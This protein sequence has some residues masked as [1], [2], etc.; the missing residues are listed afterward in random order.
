[1]PLHIPPALLHRRFRLL[2][3][4]VFVSVAGSRMQFWAILWHIRELSDQPIAL[5]GIGLVRVIPI[6]IFSLIGGSVA[7]SYDRRKVMYVTQIIFIISAS[8]LGWLTLSGKI[9][10]WNIY[11]L[12]A[13][14]A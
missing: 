1:M 11:L 6:I 9:A 2:W 5:G 12:T 13:L 14:E 10:I 8:L 4:G 7:D 3:I